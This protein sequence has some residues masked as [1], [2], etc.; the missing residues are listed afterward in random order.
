MAEERVQRRLA[1]ILAADVVGYSRLMGEDEA[2]TRARFNAHLNELIE[3]AIARERGRIVKTTGDGLLV[4]FASVVDAVQCAVEI[5]RSMAEHNAGEPDDQRMEFRIG[6]NLGDVIIEGND[7]HGDGVNVSAR[8]EEIADPGGIFISGTAFDQIRKNVD[9]GYEFLGEQEVK[10]IADPVRVYRVLT[11]PE[12]AGKIIGVAKKSPASRKWPAIAATVAVIL[13]AAVTW[14]QPW[15]PN[16]EPASIDKMAFKLPDRP[17]IAVLPFTNISGDKEQEYFSDGITEDII[18]DLSK[19]SGLFVVAR[20]S[21]FTYKGKAVEVRQIAE[22][23]G[24]RYVLEGSVRRSGDRVRINVQLIDAVKGSHVWAERYDRE[25]K[26]IFAIQDEIAGNVVAELAVTLKAHEQ[27]RIYRRHTNNL[28]AYETYLRAWRLRGPVRDANLRAKRKKLLERVI[29]L[30]PDFAGG[31]ALLS[32]IYGIEVRQGQSTSREADI[33][34]TLALAIKAVA[35]DDTFGPSYT[36]LGFAHLM[37]HQHDKAI[38]AAR[39]AI[40]IQPSDANGYAVLA[41]F[42]HWAGQGGEAIN[43]VKTAMRLNPK[44]TERESFKHTSYLGFASFT[45]GRY[46]DTIAAFNYHYALRVR[47]G[48]NT[49]SFLAA[50]YIATGQDENA[51][52]AMKAFLDKN[53]GYTLSNYQH[54]R[55]YKRT[56]DL[57][58]YLNLLR[59]AGMQE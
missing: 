52:V 1:A 40:R 42:L 23:L 18:T 35:I 11:E 59:R 31:Y 22:D 48:S 51:R 28:E 17:S 13:A 21:T 33:E 15:V 38:A 6:V 16:V 4:E 24:V 32:F 25:P 36:A 19:V 14:W 44:P 55:L 43:A 58:R 49:L 3:P 46:E 45:A 30:D 9:V 2:G 53:P 57:D 27:E 34:R 20:N 39:E 26:D 56:E 50:A 54:P 29:E 12:A 41:Y 7:I 5:Q 37:K 8:L 47:R 10:N